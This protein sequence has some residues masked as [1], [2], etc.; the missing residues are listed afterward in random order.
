VEQ[1][2]LPAT[3]HDEEHALLDAH[4]VAYRLDGPLFFGAAHQ[5]LLELSTL[6][7]TQ[8]VILRMS[9]AASLDA[10]GAA[11]LRDTIRALEHRGVTVLMS[12]IRP[13]HEAVLRAL[14]VHD[15]SHL[16]G[17]TPEAIAHARGLVARQPE[18]D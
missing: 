1:E 4:I 12:G 16:F 10:T 6:T 17:S 5:A 15:E 13:D 18:R 3:T 11:V 14:D 2:P 8:V 9:R 7:D